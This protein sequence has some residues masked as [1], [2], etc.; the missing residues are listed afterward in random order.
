[1]A[2]IVE[3]IRP[4][5]GG[6]V[7]ERVR[8]TDEPLTIGRALDNA[9][10]L[11][12]PHVDAHHAR[13]V[14]DA[15]GIVSIEDLGSVNRIETR[16]EGHRDRLTVAHGTTVVLGR[17][18]LRFRD[19][20]AIVPAAIP[21]HGVTVGGESPARWYERTNGRLGIVAAALGIAALD[22]WLGATERGA[23]SSV[24]SSLLVGSA[25]AIVWA[26]VWAI[27]ARAVLGQFRFLAHVTVFALA[28]SVY[29][30]I[31]LL[32]GW[33]AFLFPSV[34]AFAAIKGLAL[35]VLFSA[36]VAWHLGSATSLGRR[37]RWR[38]GAV[39]GVIVLAL[40]GVSGALK[41][42]AFTAAA[43]FSGVIKPVSTALVPTE[44]AE[45]FT[46]SITDLR[47]EI[48]SL[49]VVRDR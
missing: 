40:L 43:Q 16:A 44:T 4:G 18:T 5:R 48:D 36:V 32:D 11:D 42:E 33:G 45:E 37:Q 6:E 2:L 20:Q 13:L 23:A 49:L 9:L 31:D 30:A 8:L 28:V 10:V 47:G 17:T 26:G 21:L 39:A 34:T 19:E 15:E 24:F 14:R 22:T 7:R 12:D 25:V 27:A 41:D 3:V 35:V 29:A 46:R 38:I 1:M